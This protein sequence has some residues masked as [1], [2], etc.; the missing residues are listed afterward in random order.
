MG[1]ATAACCTTAATSCA[2]GWRVI[3]TRRR[4]NQWSSVCP[5]RREQEGRK[6]VDKSL[7]RCNCTPSPPLS[8]IDGRAQR[9]MYVRPFASHVLQPCVAAC[10]I[11][12]ELLVAAGASLASGSSRDPCSSCWLLRLAPAPRKDRHK[13]SAQAQW[14]LER[15]PT[16][17]PSRCLGQSSECRARHQTSCG[18]QKEKR[19]VCERRRRRYRP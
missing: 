11:A 16:S 1:V 5:R 6:V 15:L 7:K 8:R 12:G 10:L 14:P 9:Y 19:V 18:I 17:R 4:R 3:K 2:T 13:L